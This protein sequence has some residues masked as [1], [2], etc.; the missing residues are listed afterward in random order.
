MPEFHEKGFSKLPLFQEERTLVFKLGFKVPLVKSR[1]ISLSQGLVELRRISWAL[2]F[3]PCLNLSFGPFPFVLAS[4]GG[5][6]RLFKLRDQRHLTS[7]ICEPFEQRS[8][9]FCLCGLDQLLDQ[10]STQLIRFF[11][12]QQRKRD[13]FDHACLEYLCLLQDEQFL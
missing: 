6:G 1:Q 4:F 3:L 2:S 7:F 11:R 12:V 10:A 5:L 13:T 9:P 8:F